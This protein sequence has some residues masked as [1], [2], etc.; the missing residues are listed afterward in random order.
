MKKL[1]TFEQLEKGQRLVVNGMLAIGKTADGEPKPPRIRNGET[2][3]VTGAHSDS[4]EVQT[5]DGR[6]ATFCHAHGLSKLSFAP[7]EPEPE[8]PPAT[9]PVGGE[10]PDPAE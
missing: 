1:K 8:G 10:G 3:V 5:K 4:V 6:K 7:A 9:D 2:V